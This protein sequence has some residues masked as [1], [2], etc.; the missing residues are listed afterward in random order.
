M[1]Q[2]QQLAAV[3][4]RNHYKIR[5]ELEITRQLRTRT[6][7]NQSE[8]KRKAE[9]KVEDVREAKVVKREGHIQTVLVVR[10]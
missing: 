7:K 10:Q 5:A 1:Q 4:K 8:R 9:A 3:R 6:F 2:K